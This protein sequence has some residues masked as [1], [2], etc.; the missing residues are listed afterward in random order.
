MNSESTPRIVAK[1]NSA[2]GPTLKTRLEL[3]AMREAGRVVAFAVRKAFEALE[4]GI[5]TR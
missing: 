3:Q 2:L 4:Q 5:T 1:G